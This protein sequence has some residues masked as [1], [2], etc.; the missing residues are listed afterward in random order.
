M[1]QLGGKIALISGGTT[2]IGAAAARLF[3]DEGA[4]VVVTGTNPANLAA[5]REEMGVEAV[6]CDCSDVAAIRATMAT[7]GERHGR[8]DILFANAGI[9][10]ASASVEKVTEED[11]DR[12]IAVNLQ[13]V[14]FTVQAALPLMGE[15]G[16]IILTSSVGGHVAMARS[17]PYGASKAG[18]RSLG[19]SLASA[20]VERGIRVNVLTPG[21]IRTPLFDRMPVPADV[22][23]GEIAKRVP[24]ARAAE[25]IE[26]AQ[27][28]LFLA[29]PAASFVTG[30][31]YKVG[32]G[33]TDL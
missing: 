6:A 15:G 13:G 8:I 32:G 25:P 14:F 28:A 3:R 27:V 20:L 29:S 26:A 12:V 2:G 16:S 11:F 31:E 24:M 10:G 19:R 30:A 9:P 22:V 33:E 7:I 21:L 1:G 17:L 23:I 18:V 4:T 5:A